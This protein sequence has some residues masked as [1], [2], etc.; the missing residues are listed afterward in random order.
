M[1]RRV[2]VGRWKAGVASIAGAIAD[3]GPD[4]G[5]SARSGFAVVP[6]PGTLVPGQAGHAHGALRA[7]AVQTE[8]DLGWAQYDLPARA[9]SAA[10]IARLL[11]QYPNYC[12]GGK[13][14]TR[15]LPSR[16]L[17][18]EAAPS[19]VGRMVQGRQ[20][21]MGRSGPVRE[22]VRNSGQT[23]G[24]QPGG[25]RSSNCSRLPDSA[26]SA[27]ARGRPCESPAI[28]AGPATSSTAFTAPPDLRVSIAS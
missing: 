24:C 12:G 22:H 25:G 26:D 10:N 8:S 6:H 7:A 5:R 11:G 20:E 3:R 14:A 19:L 2:T 1:G 16:S 28:A 15:S 18:G 13:A 23:P 27:S 21:H 9:D 17:P 4:A